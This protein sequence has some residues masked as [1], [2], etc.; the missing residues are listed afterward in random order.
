[1]QRARKSFD[2]S[3]SS[4]S[5]AANR[6]TTCQATTTAAGSMSRRHGGGLK[7][8]TVAS[9]DWEGMRRDSAG[10]WRS[11]YHGYWPDGT[12]RGAS[13]LYW[14]DSVQDSAQFERFL[15]AKPGRMDLWL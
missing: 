15:S 6:S 13:F 12:P 11:R 1:M 14:L 3:T 8:T 9:G 5:I 2:S 4:P 7:N 10:E